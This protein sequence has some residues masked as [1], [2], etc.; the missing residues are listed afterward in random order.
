M[1]LN[2]LF[3]Y[4]LLFVFCFQ[5]FE[6]VLITVNFKINQEFFATICTNKDKPEMK[7][8]GKCHLKKQIQQ[9]EED[10]SKDKQ[11]SE[12]EYQLFFQNILITKLS[13][14]ISSSE[15]RLIYEEPLYSIQNTFDI[16]HPPKIHG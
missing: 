6:V 5:S 8:N 9:H 10:T 14:A 4:L 12:K 3:T 13:N 7:C 15:K 11:I 16:F 2:K 1:L